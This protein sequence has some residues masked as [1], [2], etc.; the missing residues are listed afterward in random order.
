VRQ[1]PEFAA[2]GAE[3]GPLVEVGGLQIKHHRDV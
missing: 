3:G 1:Q 2:H